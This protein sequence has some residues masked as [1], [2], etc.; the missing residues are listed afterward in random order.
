VTSRPATDRVVSATL[1]GSSTDRA[2]GADQN[3]IAVRD[4]RRIGATIVAI[5]GARGH[6]RGAR[7]HIGARIAADV[8]ATKAEAAVAAL[9]ST[10]AVALIGLGDVLA[11]RIAE[12]WQGQV[13][14]HLASHRT[15]GTD[16][17][18]DELSSY[19]TALLLVIVTPA[20]ALALQLGEG[21]IVMRADDGDILRPIADD[22][23]SDSSEADSLA[24]VDAQARFRHAAVDRTAHNLVLVLVASGLDDANVDPEW[25]AAFTSDVIAQ[26]E[27]DG[28][29]SVP[30]SIAG[31]ARIDG[32]DVTFALVFPAA[33][34]A[35]DAVLV[36]DATDP[37][38][39]ATMANPA[40][41][42]AA[43]T[44]ALPVTTT[45]ALRAAASTNERRRR[46]W[47]MA[48]VAAGVVVLAGGVALALSRDNGSTAPDTTVTTTPAATHASTTASTSPSTGSGPST[49]PSTAPPSTAAPSTAPSTAAPP[50]T[51]PVVVTVPTTAAPPRTTTPPRPPT[52]TPTTTPPRTTVPTTPSSTPTT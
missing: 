6:I 48:A 34:E 10:D 32:D 30:D 15:A 31:A 43:A 20:A 9:P 25:R 39:A 51:L 41:G 40:V 46:R 7:S 23:A 50:T 3:A 33:A 2:G 42:A 26:A 13:R 37:G 14:D 22:G 52:T 38:L 5:A 12:Q 35:A 24:L 4:D 36:A 18:D 44:T 27:E 45:S 19:A 47:I 29:D 21:E 49:A 11:T 16:E 8:A 28:I 1:R 17:E